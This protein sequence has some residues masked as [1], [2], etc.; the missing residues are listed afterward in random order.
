MTAQTDA[1]INTA[2]MAKD[3][4]TAIGSAGLVFLGIPQAILVAAFAGAL[5]S[6]YFRKAQPETLKK[7]IVG[8][9]AVAFAAA[10]LAVI[11]PHWRYTSSL[12]TI[13]PEALAGGIALGFNF[14]R[15][16]AGAAIEKWAM[17]KAEETA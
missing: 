6:L 1:A 8:I 14:I 17:K 11:L 5:L 12:E 2:T 15:R 9:I 10:W 16:V 3:S 4:A 7:T 13:P